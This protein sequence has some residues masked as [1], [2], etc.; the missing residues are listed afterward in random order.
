MGGV[1]T[2]LVA[3]S[4]GNPSTVRHN[5]YTV[6][7]SMSAKAPLRG[8]PGRDC[9]NYS[10]ARSRTGCAALA[11]GNVC[12]LVGRGHAP[13]TAPLPAR[14]QPDQKCAM[15]AAGGDR[16]Y[17]R[18]EISARAGVTAT[19]GGK[20]AGDG[21]WRRGRKSRTRWRWSASASCLPPDWCRPGPGYPVPPHCPAQ[22]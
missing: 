15:F 7:G 9:R 12:V 20:S 6:S 8:L 5:T 1:A 14:H 3:T 4:S 22:R 2:R 17:N 11:T 19:A 13:R 18:T 10:S 21:W 16:G